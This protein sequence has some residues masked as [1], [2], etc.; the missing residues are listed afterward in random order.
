MLPRCLKRIIKNR[1]PTISRRA[2][3]A[4][5]GDAGIRTRVLP[6]S[7][8]RGLYVRS[9][10]RLISA[11]SACDIGKYGNSRLSALN[12]DEAMR[13]DLRPVIPEMIPD[14]NRGCRALPTGMS[15]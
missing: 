7:V 6:P 2:D 5:G 1:L 15:L 10:F 4:V 14:G 3:A 8:P 12:P 13:K 9:R 11:P